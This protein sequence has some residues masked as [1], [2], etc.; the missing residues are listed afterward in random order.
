MNLRISLKADL[1]IITRLEKMGI[2]ILEALAEL[3]G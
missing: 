1:L 2:G 3:H